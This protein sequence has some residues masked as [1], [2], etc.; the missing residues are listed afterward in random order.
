MMDNFSASQFFQDDFDNG[1]AVDESNDAK[2]R[3]IARVKGFSAPVTA[4]VLIL[5]L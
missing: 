2:R 4:R 3:R 1:G 5:L